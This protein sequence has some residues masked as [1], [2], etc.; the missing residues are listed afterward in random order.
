MPRYGGDGQVYLFACKPRL[1]ARIEVIPIAARRLRLY[2]LA[3]LLRLARAMPSS[4]RAR[5]RLRLNSPMPPMIVSI[6]GRWRL[7][8]QG[9]KAMTRPGSSIPDAEQREGP[10]LDTAAVGRP[11]RR[12]D[13]RHGVKAVQ[14]APPAPGVNRAS[15]RVFRSGLRHKARPRD[16]AASETPQKQGR[17]DAP[18]AGWLGGPGSPWRQAV[19][20]K[21]RHGGMKGWSDG[22]HGFTRRVLET[23]LRGKVCRR[24]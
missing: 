7:N 19:S 6:R 23:H 1:A 22:R 11:R 17:A 9:G 5:I 8:A 21:R 3:P 14:R 4:Q 24:P 18:V 2:P 15:G 10:K 12:I 20:R 13:W 16:A